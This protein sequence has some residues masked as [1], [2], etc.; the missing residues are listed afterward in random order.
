MNAMQILSKAKAAGVSILA[1]SGQIVA[2]PGKAVTEEL[3]SLIRANKAELLK[4]LSPIVAPVAHVADIPYRGGEPDSEYV[5]A[6]DLAA[7]LTEMDRLLHQLAAIEN[8]PAP[9][10]MEKLDQRRRM[11][12]VNV[13]NALG[14]LREA[15]R[16]SLAPWPE[17]LQKR[18]KVVLCVFD[19]D[20]VSAPEYL[21]EPEAA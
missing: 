19:G 3:R 2:S 8:W 18:S 15:V 5:S 11:A 20:K 9:E 1:E 7:D 16:V 13:R 21:A 17:A 14:A 12:L 4:T 10:L 6:A